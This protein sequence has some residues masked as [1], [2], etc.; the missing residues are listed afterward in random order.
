MGVYYLLIGDASQVSVYDHHLV[1]LSSQEVKLSYKPCITT[2][3]LNSI[4]NKNR[5][6][7][8][9]IRAKD[10]VRKTNLENEYRLYKTQL[11]KTLK[12]SQSMHY[13]KFFEINKLNLRKRG[14]G[15]EKL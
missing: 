9:V 7:R 12:A 14:K 11:D 6:H 10:P 8:K 4:K 13:Q 15:L 3:I 2:G 5:R 1:K